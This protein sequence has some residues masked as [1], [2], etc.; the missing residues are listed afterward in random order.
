MNRIDPGWLPE[1]R[2]L[3]RQLGITIMA[4]G[5][6]MLTV[7]A[8]SPTRA[9][10][11]AA[12]LGHLGFK[13]IENE[14]DA[15]AGMLSL[16]KNPDAVRAHVAVAAL[17]I[18]RRRW[19][20]QIEPLIWG[21]CAIGFFISGLNH[22]GRYPAWFTFPA[23]AAL[24]LLFFWDAARIW[25]WRL[26]ILPDALRVR[27]R[28]RWTMIPWNQ[29]RKVESIPRGRNQERL[30]LHLVSHSSEP[31]GSFGGGF[32]RN[33]RDCLRQELARRN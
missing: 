33:L 13:V 5:P 14:D 30:I 19:D 4:W 3:C 2:D 24:A 26:E 1:T 10:E 21:A 9:Q 31:L 29:I 16:S 22:S 27:R 11:I 18:T 25:G 17:N 6:D 23:G 8:K 12:Q 20:E 28:F 15:Y 32:A 7:E